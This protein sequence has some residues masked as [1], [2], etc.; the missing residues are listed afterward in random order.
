MDRP[1]PTFSFNVSRGESVGEL[2]Y[3]VGDPPPDPRFL[4]SLGALSL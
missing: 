1:I 3:F 4:A 2:S